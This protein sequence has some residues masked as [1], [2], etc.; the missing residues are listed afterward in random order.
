M[1]ASYADYAAG[2]CM[3]MVPA[4]LARWL[5]TGIA[6]G[7]LLRVR[8]IDLYR[9][10]DGSL[11]ARVLRYAGLADELNAF[12]A[13]RGAP[14]VT[15]PHAK[16]GLMSDTLDPRAVLRPD[17]IARLNELFREEFETFGYPMIEP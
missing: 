9:G 7:T 16:K 14:A 17:Q 13:E 15:L 2:R 3:Q 8:N 1:Q 6:D 5:D 12:L 11:A 4:L 10:P